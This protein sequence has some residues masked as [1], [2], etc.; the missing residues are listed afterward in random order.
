MEEDD[1][2][3][4]VRTTTETPFRRFRLALAIGVLIVPTEARSDGRGFPLDLR[5]YLRITFEMIHELAQEVI[6]GRR[7]RRANVRP[8]MR[9]GWRHALERVVTNVPLRIL[10][11]SIVI[12]EIEV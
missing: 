6:Q 10:S 8:R 5:S 4:S 3:V 2:A 7:Q 11:T 1:F 12:N 9:R